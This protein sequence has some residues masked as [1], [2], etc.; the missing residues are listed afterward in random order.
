[1]P[2][3][4]FYRS[5]G[6]GYPASI[7]AFRLDGFEVTVGRM[8]A[9]ADAYDRDH[10]IAALAAGVGAHPRIPGSEWDPADSDAL[11]LDRAELDS[12]LLSCSRPTWTAATGENEDLPVNC[13]SWYLAYAFCAWDGGRLPTEA[14][15][16]YAASG[17]DLGQT[18][19]WGWRS[20]NDESAVYNGASLLPVGSKP[21]GMEV[22]WGLQDLA[23]N[24]A[25]WVLD[26]YAALSAD[27]D[28]CANVTD[29]AARVC[30]GGSAYTTWP[31]ELSAVGR[32][33]FAP[34][35]VYS[36]IGVRCARSERFEG[37][38]PGDP[39]RS[40]CLVASGPF[41]DAS[42]PALWGIGY[43]SQECKADTSD[44]TTSCT[45][46][47]GA[48]NVYIDNLNNDPDSGYTLGFAEMDTWVLCGLP[49]SLQRTATG[50]EA[51]F[52]TLCDCG[53]G[54][55]YWS[56]YETSFDCATQQLSISGYC[57]GAWPD[58]CSIEFNYEYTF[59]T[60]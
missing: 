1:M 47:G 7:G 8:R 24:V 16:E 58:P 15:W 21:D 3:G 11:P 39:G 27:C 36:D 60:L 59:S 18:F 26:G 35:S 17:G 55:D 34:S 30:R 57:M 45:H 4:T 43:H 14:E 9:F 41:D 46:D 37:Q 44:C 10:L 48:L 19:P 56:G 20:P 33:D 29:T 28:D 5:L 53:S 38:T 25:E 2:G 32:Y 49:E 42:L 40:K 54:D 13:L 50:Y 6:T 23:G 51:S 52:G 22:H 31:V 12:L